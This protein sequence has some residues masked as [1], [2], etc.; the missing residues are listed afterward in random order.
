MCVTVCT[1]TKATTC[2]FNVKGTHCH[3]TVSDFSKPEV[4]KRIGQNDISRSQKNTWECDEEILYRI[5]IP[6]EIPAKSEK[7]FK[8]N[9]CLK[10]STF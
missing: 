1:T 10:I 5:N 2:N 7:K 3:G 4:F 8:I 6:S 9:F